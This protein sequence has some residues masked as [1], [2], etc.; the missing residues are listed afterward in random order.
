M[1]RYKFQLGREIETLAKVY[2]SGFISYI[3]HQLP[4]LVAKTLKYE[5]QF[6]NECADINKQG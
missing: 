4:S 6:Y 1:F 2:N 3:F 5:N